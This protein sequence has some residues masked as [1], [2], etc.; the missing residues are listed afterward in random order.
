M[1][2]SG[3]AVRLPNLTKFFKWTHYKTFKMTE[4][5]CEIMRLKIQF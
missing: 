5:N 2:V 1:Q 3:N 4:E